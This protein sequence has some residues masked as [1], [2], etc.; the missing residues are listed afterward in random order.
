MVKYRRASLKYLP[1]RMAISLSALVRLLYFKPQYLLL[2]AISSFLF[3]E[4]IFWFLNLG[5]AHY[6]FVSPYLT[7]S[8]KL[9][10]V[11]GSYS[12]IF[13]YP[14]SGLALTLFLVS[15]LQ[16]VS[17]SAIVYTIRHERES[18]K[19]MVKNLG[20][21]GIAALLSVLGL[22]CAACGSSLVTPILT[23]LFASSSVALA[24]TVGLYSALLALV[25]AIVTA[26]LAGIKLAPKLS[27]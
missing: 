8:D 10:I 5:L 3:Y 25:V 13:A 26:Y 20:G 27:T 17:I 16:G 22:G 1:K 24:E 23:F 11:I 2:A 12:G 19:G 18:N 14:F 6:L 21:T 9:G 15:A 4:L 7:L